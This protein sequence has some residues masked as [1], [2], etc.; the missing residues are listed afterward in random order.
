MTNAP[1]A[2]WPTMLVKPPVSKTQPSFAD[3]NAGCIEIPGFDKNDSFNARE[4][5]R[6]GPAGGDQG[7]PVLRHD[8]HGLQLRR[9]RPAGTL[10]G[11][12]GVRQIRR[13]AAE[14]RPRSR[15]RT[16][17]TAP[18]GTAVRDRPGPQ[19][20]PV[21]QDEGSPPPR[22]VEGAGHMVPVDNPAAAFHAIRTLLPDSSDGCE[23]S[24]LD[25]SNFIRESERVGVGEAAGRPRPARAVVA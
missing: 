25:V 20:R 3:C 18:P 19:R 21:G 22:P 11:V 2:K 13:G 12:A 17:G 8:G 4:R 24:I 14:G 1:K 6:R 10:A 5:A 7:H 23:G 9:R 15:C 16:R